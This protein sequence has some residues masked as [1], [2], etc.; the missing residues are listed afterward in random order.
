MMVN[1]LSEFHANTHIPVA[2]G[3]QMRYEITV[4]PLYKEIGTYFMDIVN[5]L[6]YSS[7]DSIVVSKWKIS[8][9]FFL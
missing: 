2:I 5:S 4:D 9:T 7:E 6:Q 3:A 1:S 8:G